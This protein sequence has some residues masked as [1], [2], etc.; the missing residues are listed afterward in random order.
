MCMLCTAV[1]IRCRCK[2]H[3][4]VAEAVVLSSF[5]CQLFSMAADSTVFKNFHSVNA[6]LLPLSARNTKV[7]HEQVS[8]PANLRL[9][10][11]LSVKRLFGMSYGPCAIEVPN[12][13]LFSRFCGL[14]CGYYGQPGESGLIMVPVCCP[15]LTVMK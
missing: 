15:G 7:S 5:H 2:S 13:T 4:P 10:F 1:H 11:K 8:I 12:R 9:A 14:P 6:N 3:W